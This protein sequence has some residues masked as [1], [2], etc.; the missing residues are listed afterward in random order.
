MMK[1]NRFDYIGEVLGYLTCTSVSEVQGKRGYKHIY[2]CVCG[3]TREAMR[4]D[5]VKSTRMGSFVSCGC[6]NR[7]PIKDIT[8]MKKGKLTALRSTGI[9]SGNGDY[10]WL[11]A[12]ECGNIIKT[13]IGRFNFSHTRSC[14]CLQKESQRLR[15]SY[16]GMQDTPVY[17]SWRKIKERC[18]NK[19]DVSYP[20]YGGCGVTMSDEL[21]DSFMDFYKYIG[22]PPDDGNRYSI[23]RIS[24]DSGYVKGNIR[25]ATSHEQA[26]NK[27]LSISNSSGVKGV[28]IDNKK[29]KGAD[30]LYAKAIWNNLEGKQVSKVFSYRK[31]GEEL[32]MFLAE[33]YRITMLERLNL[34]GAGYT[35]YH[36]YGTA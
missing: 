17:N 12:C 31:Y 28:V 18:Y 14:G 30:H 5:L 4:G 8:G 32:A 2:G 36:I 6:K 16:H 9:T 15:D 1:S 13:T 11:F 22:D 33:E 3:S 25:W 7:K 27:G 21:R 29:Y 24:N 19:N 23:D 26:R 34:L 35:D 10:I 20:N